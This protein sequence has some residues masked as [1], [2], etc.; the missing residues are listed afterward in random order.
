MLQAGHF[1]IV[2]V[3]IKGSGWGKV[4]T[5]G[6]AGHWVVVTGFSGQWHAGSEDS[7]WN[8][9]RINNPFANRVEYYPWQYF[10]DSM[11]NQ[12]FTVGELWHNK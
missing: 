1:V 5:T 3:T 11:H 12:G 9:V 8:W 10:K 2:G 6:G 7:E 4:I